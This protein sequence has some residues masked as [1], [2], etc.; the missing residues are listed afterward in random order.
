MVILHDKKLT[1]NFQDDYPN[2]PVQFL[3]VARD[4][5][6]PLPNGAPWGA[7]TA[8]TTNPYQD[9]PATG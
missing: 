9:P 2:L 5:S 1:N 4:Q 3:G 7:R 8:N 6:L